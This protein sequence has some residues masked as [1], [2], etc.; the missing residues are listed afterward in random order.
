MK[1]LDPDYDET[2]FKDLSEDDPL[3]IEHRNLLKAKQAL[4]SY[5]EKRAT[6]KK[7]PSPQEEAM[8][9]SL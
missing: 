9:S 8:K 5:L 3:R 6:Q 2:L 7:K 1:M 4:D